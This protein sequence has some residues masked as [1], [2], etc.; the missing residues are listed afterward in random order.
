[1]AP[2]YDRLH[3]DYVSS[4]PRKAKLFRCKQLKGAETGRKNNQPFATDS[5]NVGRVW[6]NRENILE[7][8]LLT[9]G[10]FS[11]NFTYS[12]REAAAA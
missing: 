5:R 4:R 6:E 7:K 8:F 2:R 11:T 12:G 10:G 3:F 1:M 9:L